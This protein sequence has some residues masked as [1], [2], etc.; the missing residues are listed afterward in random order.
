[1]S[2]PLHTLKDPEG[3]LFFGIMPSALGVMLAILQHYKL[4]AGG[5]LRAHY[6]PDIKL[7]MLQLKYLSTLQPLLP[8]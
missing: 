8:A 3:Q 7:E 5:S 1:M 6:L 2:K 4:D